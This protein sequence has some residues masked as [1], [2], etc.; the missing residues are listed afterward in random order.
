M[1]SI[2]ITQLNTTESDLVAADVKLDTAFFAYRPETGDLP[3]ADTDGVLAAYKA[4]LEGGAQA[5]VGAIVYATLTANNN[6]L[7]TQLAETKILGEIEKA[8]AADPDFTTS[9]PYKAYVV[10]KTA[11]ALSAAD[12][13][14]Q[15]GTDTDGDGTNDTQFVE[16]FNSAADAIAHHDALGA[17]VAGADTVD[18]DARSTD[19]LNRITA[20]SNVADFENGTAGSIAEF[21]QVTCAGIFAGAKAVQLVQ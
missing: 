7:A 1:V 13:L 2:I 18:W 20:A 4:T 9:N 6:G 19:L 10:S 21:Q 5:S 17:A 11:N 8:R 16:F 15:Y 12:K 3:I 14:A